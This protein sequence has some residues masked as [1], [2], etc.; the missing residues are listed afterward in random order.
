MARPTFAPGL[1]PDTMRS[2]RGPNAPRRE[3]ITHRP[4][5]PVTAHASSTPSTRVLRTSGWIRCSA[6][7]AA[8]APEYSRSG[9][10]ITTSPC[11][12]IARA[13][14]C[15]PT[16]SMPSSF[17]TRIRTPQSLAVGVC[18]ALVGGDGVRTALADRREDGEP[19][20]HEHHARDLR[21]PDLLA[22]DQPRPEHRERRL[23]RLQH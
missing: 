16:E 19:D 9:A 10:A 17:V 14:T 22:E 5:G 15:R 2:K 8:P 21:G 7:S 4:G 18:G 3:N 6:P 13:S 12:R 1:M 20:D 11:G 23:P